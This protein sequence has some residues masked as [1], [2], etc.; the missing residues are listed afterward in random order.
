MKKYIK[1]NVRTKG[2]TVNWRIGEHILDSLCEFQGNL[3][4]EQISHNPDK[5]D[6]PFLGKK[7]VENFW[8]TPVTLSYSGGT[9]EVA[10]TFA[11]RRKKIGE[12]FGLCDSYKEKYKISDCSWGNQL[13]FGLR[14]ESKFL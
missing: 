1:I 13:Y 9:F 3:L 5:F 11:W 7:C 2:E 8:V 12:I 10:D 6:A 4:P 14:I